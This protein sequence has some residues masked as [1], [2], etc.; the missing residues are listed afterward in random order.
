MLYYLSKSRLNLLYFYISTFCSMCAVRSMAIFCSSLISCFF[1]II[2]II[3]VVIIIIIIVIIVVI[4]T[5]F[6]GHW[7]GDVNTGSLLCHWTAA[8]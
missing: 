8:G 2:M 3:V 6:A 7:V 1:F 4:V 5:H